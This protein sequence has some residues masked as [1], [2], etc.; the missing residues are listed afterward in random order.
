[1]NEHAPQNEHPPL[2]NKDELERVSQKIT[3]V[4]EEP[5]QTLLVS[6]IA[7]PNVAPTTT[8]TPSSEELEKERA[9]D[10]EARK[11]AEE[12]KKDRDSLYR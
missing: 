6:E 8:P 2:F 12:D 5:A 9:R 4:H 1:M 3:T 10:H 7:V 11:I